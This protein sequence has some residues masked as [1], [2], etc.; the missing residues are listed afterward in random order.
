MKDDLISDF[1]RVMVLT[2][3]QVGVFVVLYDGVVEMYA[4]YV[5]P[6]KRLGV[7]YGISLELGLN[8]LSVLACLNAIAQVFATRIQIRFLTAASA[9]VVWI[10]FWR[11][12]ADVVPNRVAL[13]S[14]AGTAS[15]ATGVLFMFPKL[16]MRVG[17]R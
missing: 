13:L 5:G 11:T 7:S 2:A 4:S 6:M 9:A 15:F 3:I 14:V 12:I 16:E 8:L 1:V 10:L 17:L